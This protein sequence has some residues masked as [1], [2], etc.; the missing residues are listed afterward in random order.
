MRSCSH[1]HTLRPKCYVSPAHV[2]A[3]RGRPG[4][5]CAAGTS[6]LAL[7]HHGVPTDIVAERG[8]LN[9][10]MDVWRGACCTHHMNHN[11]A[12]CSQLPGGI[13]LCVDMRRHEET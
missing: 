7:R 13:L 9:P 2:G 5:P 10:G 12:L 1:A 6:L 8:V 4:T 11:Q 3:R